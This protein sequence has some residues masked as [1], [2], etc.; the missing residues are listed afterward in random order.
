[1]KEVKKKKKA[2]E[3][4]DEGMEFEDCKQ[5]MEADQENAI[6]IADRK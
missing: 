2:M 6:D 4:R 3:I 5:G 1:L